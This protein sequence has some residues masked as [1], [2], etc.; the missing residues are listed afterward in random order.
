MVWRFV[1][2]YVLK[3]IFLLLWLTAKNSEIDKVLGLEFGADDYVTKPFSNRELQARVKAL[4]RR[5]DLTS[6]DNQESDEN[7]TQPLQIGDLEI[8]PDAYVAK[9]YGEELDLTHREFE[10]LYHLA[11]HIGQVITREHLLKLSGVMIISETFEQ[12][13]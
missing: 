6:V 8:V 11:S 1:E 9:K 13:M 12:L 3:K 10:L 5:T 4:L 7:K 2:K